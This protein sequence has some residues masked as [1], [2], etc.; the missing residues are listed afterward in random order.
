MSLIPVVADMNAELNRISAFSEVSSS[1][2]IEDTDLASK[3]NY[4]VL[5]YFWSMEFPAPQI[6]VNE[7]QN[8]LGLTQGLSAQ[9]SIEVL[10]NFMRSTFKVV[11]TDDGVLPSPVD[12]IN[13]VVER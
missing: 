4:A 11:V 5:Y 12:D 9:T 6:Q 10:R 3:H 8:R 13:K 1:G 2:F 7:E